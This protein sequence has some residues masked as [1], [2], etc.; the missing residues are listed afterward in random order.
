MC[1]G[2]FALSMHADGEDMS[3]RALPV[4]L[5][6]HPLALLTSCGPIHER[7]IHLVSHFNPC[8]THASGYGSYRPTA[9][10]LGKLYIEM[11]HGL[12]RVPPAPATKACRVPGISCGAHIDVEHTYT[13]HALWFPVM[14]LACNSRTGVLNMQI[15]PRPRVCPCADL[16]FLRLRFQVL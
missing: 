9:G 10:E 12:S 2:A 11:H 16:L 13:G 7:P 15:W 8:R 5:P 6:S 14:L 1:A 4:H 3:C